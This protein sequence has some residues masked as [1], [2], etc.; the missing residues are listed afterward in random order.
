MGPQGNF[1]S[2]NAGAF[3]LYVGGGAINAGFAR[4]LGQAGHDTSGYKEAHRA[5]Y[6]AAQAAGATDLFWSH[7]LV[8]PLALPEGLASTAVLLSPLPER[9]DREGTRAGTVFVDVFAAGREPLGHAGN[10]G[11][12]YAIGPE[13]S[14]AESAQDFVG[15]C[16]ATGEAML[17][18]LSQHN[19]AGGAARLDVVRVC[20]ISGGIF[21]HP[22][23]EKHEVAGALFRGISRGFSAAHSPRLEFAFDEDVFRLAY[24]SLA[25]TA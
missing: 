17:R 24:Q 4:A 25:P 20:L 9:F 15:G 7:A 1:A 11:M 14:Q 2:V 10:I 6:S 21:K 3:A 12:V 8:P 16:E 18:A 19:S 23:V 13:G 5:L 22:Q